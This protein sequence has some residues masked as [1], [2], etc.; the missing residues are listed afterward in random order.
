MATGEAPDAVELFGAGEAVGDEED[1]AVSCGF[2]QGGEK[3][4][5]GDGVEAGAG[6]VQ[7]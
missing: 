4:G 3:G 5:F 1:G 6:F 2:K 7:D